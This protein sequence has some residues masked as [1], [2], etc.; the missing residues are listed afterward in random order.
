MKQLLFRQKPV[1]PPQH[2]R[3]V[4]EG[5]LVPLVLPQKS[6][7][8]LLG[9]QEG[10]ALLVYPQHAG[11]KHMAAQKKQ[12]LLTYCGPESCQSPEEHPQQPL[13]DRKSVV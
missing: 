1:Q 10:P 2:G 5:Q 7:E 8:L 4:V 3:P 12:R 11:A 13:P 6:Q 9:Q